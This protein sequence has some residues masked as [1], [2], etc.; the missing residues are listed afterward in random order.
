MGKP[1][2]D[3]GKRA[4]GQV[5]TLARDCGHPDA[6]R[7]WR[8]P[9]LNGDIR[10]L[11]GPLTHLEVRRHEQ[12]RI[13]AWAREV[14]AAASSDR[15]PILAF[16]RNKEPWRAVLPLDLLLRLLAATDPLVLASDTG[17]DTEAADS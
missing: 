14:E 17:G 6:E 1:S 7:D 2:R 11:V 12:P 10:G 4:E 5:V 13:E 16:R 9:Q 3:K 15:L 8:T